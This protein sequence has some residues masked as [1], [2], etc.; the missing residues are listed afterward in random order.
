MAELM[1]HVRVLADQ[2]GPRPVSTEEEHQSS[3]YIAQE[4]TD[5]GLE[6]DVDEF[7][8]PTGV[9]WPYAVAFL[10]VTLGT[11]IT[12]MGIFVPGIAMTMFLI[13]IVFIVVGVVIYYA[14][15][16]GKPLL[17]RMRSGGVSQNVVA[18][19]IPSSVA[20]ES[21]RRKV[22]IVA[23]VDTVRAQPEVMPNFVQKTPL[24]RK[25]VFYDA[26]AVL[27]LAIVRLLPLPWPDVVDLIL[28]IISL[29][30][31]LYLLAAAGCIVANKFMPYIAGGNDNASSVAVLLGTAKRLLDPEERE[32]HAVG[33]PVD[34][35]AENPVETLVSSGTGSFAPVSDEGQPVVHGEQAAYAAGVVPEGVELEYAVEKAEI[36]VAAFGDD[37]PPMTDQATQVMNPVG[38]Q[39]V[40]ETPQV[41]EPVLVQP[42]QDDVSAGES[43]PSLEGAQLEPEPAP[44]PVQVEVPKAQPKAKPEDDGL[45]SWYKAA[46]E[47]AAKDLAEKEVEPSAV[48]DKPVRSTRETPEQPAYYRSRFA[49]MPLRGPVH[50]EEE[51]PETSEQ[52]EPAA[53]VQEQQVQQPAVDATAAQPAAARPAAVH[54]AAGAQ[55]GMPEVTI[56]KHVPEREAAVDPETRAALNNLLDVDLDEAPRGGEHEV[57]SFEIPDDQLDELTPDVSGMFSTVS[58]QG[59]AHERQDEQSAPKPAEGILGGLTSRIPFIGDSKRE[60]DGAAS[61]ET[62]V[63]NALDSLSIPAIGQ[64][65]AEEQDVSSATMILDA[66]EIAQSAPER[67]EEAPKPKIERRKPKARHVS[68]NFQPT[69]APGSRAN[70][71]LGNM[72]QAAPVSSTYEDTPQAFDPFAPREERETYVAPSPSVSSSFPALSGQMPAVGG[73][74]FGASPSATSSFPSLTGSFPA[75]SGQMPTINSADFG[76]DDYGYE[77]VARDVADDFLSPG[78]TSEIDIPESRFHNA[79]DK[80]GGLFSRKKKGRKGRDRH[81]A[82]DAEHWNEDDDFGWKGGAFLDESESAFAAAKARAAEIRDSVVSMTE[83]DLLDKEVWFVALG[84]SGAGNQGMKNFLDLHGPE[85]RGALIINL[86]CVGAG[87]IKYVDFEGTGKAVPSDRRLQSLVRSAS[88]EVI[89]HEMQHQ[90]LDWRNTDATPALQ[91]GM[92]AL[93]IMGFDGVAPACWHWKTDTIDIVDEDNLEYVTKVLLKVIE[94][95]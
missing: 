2:I 52:S 15:H 84:A 91:A 64:S 20:R 55:D 45:P 57:I 17:S 78:M 87:E 77:P 32:K 1:E 85:L 60:A 4:L 73:S 62:A 19:Y 13:G 80:V 58:G 95:A 40:V 81:D 41:V 28:W 61:P 23:H 49:D 90:K 47:K 88:K 66:E 54:V 36:D 26:L 50:R 82:G 48:E 43:L 6:V 79:M 69:K 86:E 14:E 38:V 51:Q 89:G 11:L 10:A 30:G 34:V 27:A 24:M 56:A 68:E 31:C 46:K 42:V 63:D 21:R 70:E 9:R 39:G 33:K 92:R 8:T 93:S 53:Q 74:D 72:R 75:L 59:A 44:A 18:R 83:S 3:L 7:A 67:K 22:V 25:I 12:G 35:D 29:I 71:V 94:E 16:N 5:E 37:I 65:S 76:E